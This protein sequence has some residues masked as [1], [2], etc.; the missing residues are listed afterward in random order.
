MSIASRSRG[1]LLCL[2]LAVT[3]ISAG[4]ATGIAFQAAESTI[5]AIEQGQGRVY[6][7]RTAVVGAAVQP[8]VFLNDEPVGKAVP[9]G[10]FYVDRLPGDYVVR[11]STEVKRELSFTLAPGETRYVRLKMQFGV[12]VGHVRPELVDSATALE[13]MRKTKLVDRSG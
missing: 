12:L 4:C 10:F 7:Y 13:E 5:P 6:F 2:V 3:G 8:K 1:M 9:K 11:C